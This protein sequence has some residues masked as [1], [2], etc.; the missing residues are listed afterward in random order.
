MVFGFARTLGD[1]TALAIVPRL[2]AKATGDEAQYPVGIFW[3][4]TNLTL[5]GA[6]LFV[7]VFTGR[8]FPA[9]M[10]AYL[11]DIFKDLPFALL[12]SRPPK[13]TAQG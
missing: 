6:G 1:D 10:L 9:G 5:P 2:F 3:D 7:D 12:V 13:S 8:E 4:D 11:K